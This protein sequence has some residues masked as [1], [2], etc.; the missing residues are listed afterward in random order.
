MTR[1]CGAIASDGVGATTCGLGSA[2]LGA[3]TG[4]SVA[5]GGSTASRSTSSSGCVFCGGSAENMFT[6]AFVVNSG[7]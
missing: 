7:G 6:A 1:S 2:G 4:G 5:F 3:A